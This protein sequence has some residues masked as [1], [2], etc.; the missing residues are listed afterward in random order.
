MLHC[1]LLNDISAIKM[2]RRASQ[3]IHGASMASELVQGL[4]GLLTTDLT[5]RF[6]HING[7]IE[8]CITHLLE[9]F[10][11]I[12][13]RSLLLSMFDEILLLGWIVHPFEAFLNL[14]RTYMWHGHDLLLCKELFP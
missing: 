14:C 3:R 10:H 2:K 5:D 13:I 12:L 8:L 9:D 7:A 6:A 4:L 11:H 1:P